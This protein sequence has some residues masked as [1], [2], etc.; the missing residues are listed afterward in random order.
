MSLVPGNVY[1]KLFLERFEKL[2]PVQCWIVQTDP[3]AELVVA[4]YVNVDGT[5][6][7]LYEYSIG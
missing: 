3:A 1:V 7:N 5:A 6:I 2:K 4:L